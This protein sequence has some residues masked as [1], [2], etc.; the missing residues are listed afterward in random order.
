MAEM[1]TYLTSD[2]HFGHLKMLETDHRPRPFGSVDEMNRVLI[3]NWNKVVVSNDKDIVWVLG[4]F[5]L[6]TTEREMA[7]IFYQLRG[8]KKLVIGNHDVDNRGAVKEALLR[9][10]WDDV[11]T[12]RA[13][14]KH[15]RQRIILDHYAGLTWN[16][17]HHG[18]YLAYGHSH[19]NLPG[20]PGAIDVG[21]DVQNFRPISVEEFVR[22]ADDSMRNWEKQLDL[23]IRNLKGRAERYRRKVEEIREER[24]LSSRKV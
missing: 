23:V 3:A 24:P 20:L 11:A 14:I 22:Q 15:G 4:D 13:E 5:A 10:P 2:P 8:R 19:G 17:D 16:A 12:H 6:G 7:E 21:M 1:T 9:L 18:S